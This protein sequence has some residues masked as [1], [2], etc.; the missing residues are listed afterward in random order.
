MT[1]AGAIPFLSWHELPLDLAKT[2]VGLGSHFF[3]PPMG[4][5]R[6]VLGVSN[7]P[8]GSWRVPVGY[9]KYPKLA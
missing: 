7:P 6:R 8:V 1:V 5:P 2:R 9:P 4:Y 3:G